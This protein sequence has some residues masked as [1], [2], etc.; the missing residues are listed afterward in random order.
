MK[1]RF[2]DKMTFKINVVNEISR[3]KNGKL[4]FIKNETKIN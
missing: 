1:Q 2:G 3:E 4:R